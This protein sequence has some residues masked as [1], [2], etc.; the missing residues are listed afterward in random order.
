M[1]LTFDKEENRSKK[2]QDLLPAFPL[3]GVMSSCAIQVKVH[4][5]GCG[6]SDTATFNLW[7]CEV[8]TGTEF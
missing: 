8:I 1:G 4:G 2:S 5:K 6:D 7:G 3:N